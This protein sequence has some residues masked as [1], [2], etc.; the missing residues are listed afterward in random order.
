MPPFDPYNMIA[1]RL[2]GQQFD[3]TDLLTVTN[4]MVEDIEKLIGPRLNMFN[5]EFEGIYFASSHPA[6]QY[7]IRNGRHFTKIRL[8]S[9]SLREPGNALWQL[10]LM[11]ISEEDVYAAHKEIYGWST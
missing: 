7:R 6:M 4:F 8:A 11:N 5:Y 10:P 1:R 3:K 9:R 2:A